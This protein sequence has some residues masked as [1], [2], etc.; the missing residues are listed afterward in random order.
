MCAAILAREK[1]D[2]NTSWIILIG[3]EALRT[4]VRPPYQAISW[5]SPKQAPCKSPW[6]EVVSFVLPNAVQADADALAEAP[7]LKSETGPK[8][9][10]TT[11]YRM[12][13]WAA[14]YRL[15]CPLR[16]ATALPKT[17]VA[18]VIDQIEQTR[19]AV[20]T[21]FGIAPDA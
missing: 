5:Y 13:I 15:G 3:L 14:W 1:G 16:G 9:S 2:A 6:P 11:L 12:A 21:A 10:V 7:W 4:G 8:M 17:E 19:Q 18:L 20:L